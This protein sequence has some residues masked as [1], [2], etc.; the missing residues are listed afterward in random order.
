LALPLGTLLTQEI[1]PEQSGRVFLR[2]TLAT[3]FRGKGVG[4]I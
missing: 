2:A 1:R 3:K 4:I